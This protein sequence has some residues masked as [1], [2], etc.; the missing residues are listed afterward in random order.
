MNMHFKITSRAILLLL[1]SVVFFQLTAQENKSTF[2]KQ[3]SIETSD[4]Y[5]LATD[6]YLPNDFEKFPVILFR[7]PYNKENLKNTAKQM[8]SHGYAVVVQDCRGTNSSEDGFYAFK[9]EKDDG[10][11]TAQWIT[12]QSWCNGNIGTAGGSYLGYTQWISAPFHGNSVKTMIPEV[13]LSDLHKTMYQNGAFFLGLYVPWS[14]GMT[15]PSIVPGNPGLQ[16]NMDSVRFSLPLIEIDKEVGWK[17]PFL[18]DWLS[19]PFKDKSW[20]NTFL[21]NDNYRNIKTSVYNIGGWY[22]IFLKNT[23][24]DFLNMTGEDILPEIREKQKLLI[25]PWTHGW[26]KRK[27]GELDFGKEAQISATDIYLPWFD[28]QLKGIDNKMMEEPPVKIFVMGANKWRFENEWPLVRTKYQKYFFHSQGNANSLNGNGRLSTISPQNEPVDKFIYDPSYPVVSNN[29][30]GPLDQTS[31]EKRQDV[32]IYTSPLLNDDLE[33][34]GPVRAVIHASSSA[35]NTDFTAKLVDV[36]PDGRAIRICEGII[37]ASHR[38]P[39]E[40]PTNI[41]PGKIYEYHI[42]LWATSNLFK[43]GHRIRVEISSSCFPRF[44]RNLNTGNNF[45]TD[46]S[47]IKAEQIIYHNEIYPS[48]IILP[49]ISD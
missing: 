49:V 34:T 48:C 20:E 13:A 37:R 43:K 1:L 6:V 32:L 17:T 12:E 8:V 18:R 27:E 9:N 3:E 21:E 26:G 28:S 40:F 22:D 14:L 45:A 39:N 42:D 15:M 7:T 4:G 25:G 46:A 41:E 2:L 33:V 10:I 31:I 5:R 24:D 30:M 36:Y 11:T 16:P 44:D 19:H 47:G 23:I 35:K 29:Y 38:N